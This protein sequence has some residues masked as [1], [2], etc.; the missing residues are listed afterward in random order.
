[1]QRVQAELESLEGRFVSAGAWA[2][3]AG[4]ILR[5]LMLAVW[6]P[7]QYYLEARFG[8]SNDAGLV[9]ATPHNLSG[10]RCASGGC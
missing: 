3:V 7:H 2:V 1:M 9:P 8:L 4:F 6:H 10:I 5:G